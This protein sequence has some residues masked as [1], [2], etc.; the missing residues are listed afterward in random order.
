MAFKFL[1]LSLSCLSAQGVP[2]LN[3]EESSEVAQDSLDTDRTQDTDMLQVIQTWEYIELN[4][5]CIAIRD[6]RTASCHWTGTSLPPQGGVS[7]IT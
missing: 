1:S 2:E 6:F 5:W 4:N 7:Q 3:V